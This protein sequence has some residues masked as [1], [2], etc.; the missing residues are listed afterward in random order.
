MRAHISSLAGRAC[1]YSCCSSHSPVFFAICCLVAFQLLVQAATVAVGLA[2]GIPS[3]GSPGELLLLARWLTILL[4]SGGSAVLWECQPHSARPAWAFPLKISQAETWGI[5]LLWISSIG[6]HDLLFVARFVGAQCLAIPVHLV[7][8]LNRKPCL[9]D[10][11]FLL[12]FC[13]VLVH[14]LYSLSVGVWEASEIRSSP[15]CWSSYSHPAA[16]VPI[17]APWDTMPL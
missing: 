11:G 8:W 12:W 15:V 1:W 16:V 6:T 4:V 14:S 5:E 7:Q 9:T 2:D 3:P 13:Q 10:P 17:I